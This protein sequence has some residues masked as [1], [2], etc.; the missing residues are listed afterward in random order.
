MAPEAA[1][2]SAI[3]ALEFPG[4]RVT[5]SPGEKE[6]PPTPAASPAARQGVH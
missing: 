2:A 1:V 4:R 6:E 3:Y 5:P